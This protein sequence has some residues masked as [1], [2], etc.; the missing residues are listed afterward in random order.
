MSIAPS[1]ALRRI[2]FLT[3][4]VLS[5]AAIGRQAQCQ[6]TIE[7]S[8]VSLSNKASLAGTSYF[9][10]YGVSFADQ[11]VYVIDTRLI[12]AGTD[13]YGI[14]GRD[15]DSNAPNSAFSILFDTSAYSVTYDSATLRTHTLTATAYN[16][17]DQVL[18]AFT[19]SGTG[20]VNYFTHTFS[21]IGK[22][23]KITFNGPTAGEAIGR[24]EYSKTVGAQ[25]APEPGSIALVVGFG[26]S[27]AG[28]LRR[29]HTRS[30]K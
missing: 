20:D 11:A 15:A 23:K 14:N 9:D 8:E 30:R 16:S 17:S 26:V 7:F 2:S 18:G 28:L 3:L 22:I 27:S 13:K 4:S 29:R 24:L 1:A 19:Q 12:G 21:G 25:D 5:F 6:T 10:A